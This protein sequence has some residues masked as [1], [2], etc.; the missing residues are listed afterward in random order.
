VK[1]FK[2]I[3]PA[4][5]RIVLV[6]V[7]PQIMAAFDPKLAE[8]AELSIPAYPGVYVVGDMASLELRPLSICQ[9]SSQPPYSPKHSAGAGR[10]VASS[11]HFHENFEVF[12]RTH[13]LSFGRIPSRMASGS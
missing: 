12:P 11:Q 10:S 4:Q 3:N 7:S 5:A 2:H 8:H 6:E 9:D 13:A 1:D